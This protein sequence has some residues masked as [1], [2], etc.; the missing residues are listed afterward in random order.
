MNKLMFIIFV[1]ILN[2]LIISNCYALVITI[3]SPQNTTYTTTTIWLNVTADETVNTWLYNLNNAGNTSFTPNITITAQ[4]GQNKITVWAND[5]AGNWNMSEVWFYANVTPIVTITSPQNTTYMTNTIWL[6]W[7]SSGNI[8]NSY[9]RLNKDYGYL[10][11]YNYSYYNQYSVGGSIIGLSV[12]DNYLYIEGYGDV[13]V[14]RKSDFSQVAH[15]MTSNYWLTDNCIDNS[16]NYFFVCKSDIVYAY[17]KSN[18]TQAYT[19]TRSNYDVEDIACD[20]NL[21]FIFY[22][23]TLIARYYENGTYIDNITVVDDETKMA[24]G[25]DAR[26]GYLAY[27]FKSGNSYKS[28]IRYTNFTFIRQYELTEYALDN[29][30]S[31]GRDAVFV[32]ATNL[33]LFKL[34]IHENNFSN[35]TL[36]GTAEFVYVNNNIVSV[37]TYTYNLVCLYYYNLTSNGNINVSTGDANDWTKT[38][39]SDNNYI[40]IGRGAS[41]NL[42]VYDINNITHF[43]TTILANEGQNYLYVYTENTIGNSNYSAVSF[44][45]DTTPPSITIVSPS[46]ITYNHTALWFNITV[47]ETNKDTC[48]LNLDGVNYTM[49]NSGDNYYLY[50]TNLNYSIHNTTYYCNDTAGHLTKSDTVYFTVVDSWDVSPDTYVTSIN[51]T[52]SDSFNITVTESGIDNE[53]FNITC[54]AG[55]LCNETLFTL[56][57]NSSTLFVEG[58]NS[59]K[60]LITIEPTSEADG[61]YPNNII[62]VIRLSDNS[63]KNVTVNITVALNPGNIIIVNPADKSVVM[64]SDEEKSITFIAK[65]NGIGNLTNCV[66]SLDGGFHSANWVYY[67]PQSFNLTSNEQKI[68]TI[69]FSNPPVGTYNTLEGIQIECQTAGGIDTLNPDDRF[70]VTLSVLA[71][72]SPSG[73]G[74]GNLK[75]ELKTPNLVNFF[76]YEGGCSTRNVTFIWIGRSPAFMHFEIPKELQEYLVKPRDGDKILMNIGT[77]KI[78][79]TV[80]LPENVKQL[81]SYKKEMNFIITV[82][83]KTQEIEI[84]INIYVREVPF[85]WM[86]SSIYLIL[87]I[88]IIIVAGAYL[89]IPTK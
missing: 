83:I 39:I 15:P 7:T 67:L 34:M 8:V 35:I 75:E 69:T 51:Q 82:R 28:D 58:R 57:I 59:N 74:G 52:G 18:L 24:I 13:W 23:D 36:C 68:I 2:L 46:N 73:G 1:I 6:S 32:G 54:L 29:S 81:L 49:S 80:C 41:P 26:Y 63:K 16:D 66:T 4:E 61:N 86:P 79:F 85:K 43:N 31:I 44:L 27:T 25:I 84:P 77:N 30:I 88:I 60:T 37:A 33:K 45:V 89:L 20:D 56:T 9:Y 55:D 87:A 72:P 65:N 22:S 64:Y 5:T 38:A 78:E 70:Q 40:Y 21:L 76:V 48:L 12:D 71:R 62:Q 19:I 42:V 3:H 10:Y 11:Y 50:K 53:T 14:Y 17:Y 47:S